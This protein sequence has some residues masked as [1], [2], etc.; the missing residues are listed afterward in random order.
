MNKTTLLILRYTFWLLTFSIMVL[1]FDFSSQSRTES[2]SVSR[3]ITETIIKFLYNDYENLPEETRINLLNLI[4]ICVRKLAHFTAFFFM[5]G[6]S[7]NSMLTYNVKSKIKVLV[8]L[9]IGLAY[10]IFDELHQVMVPGR[11][12]GVLDVLL[13]FFGCFCGTACVFLIARYFERRKKNE[14]E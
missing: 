14:R 11:G 6:F 1:L 12:P 4:H 9:V 5:G 10:A 3:G 8:P 2:A 13:D 7:S